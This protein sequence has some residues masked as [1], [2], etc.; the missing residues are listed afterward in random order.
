MI[1]PLVSTAF[2]MFL[3]AGAQQATPASPAPPRDEPVTQFF[4]N[5]GRDLRAVPSRETAEI[6][7][8]AA[9]TA[10]LAHRGDAAVAE[11]AKRQPSSSLGAFGNFLGD[12]W[13]QWGAAASVWFAGERSHQP[14]VAHLGSDL[15][16]AQALNGVINT[17][18]KWTVRRERPTGSPHSFPS[19]HTSATFATAAVLEH[20][21][22]WRAGAVAYGVAAFV[23]WAR[24]R[25]YQHWMSDVVFGAAVGVVSG[26]S[27]SRT[28]P[29]QWT[30]AP[31][32]TVGGIA[33]F[34]TRQPGARR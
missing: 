22:G 6:F 26:R 28:H 18:I 19:G 11:W 7:T 9:A 1:S 15:I 14:R 5:L 30:V 25:T 2:A 32:K 4:Q 24:V 10:L 3:I 21:L 17:A 33:V 29:R 31:V 20:H 23:G 8:G 12:G 27:V 34:V 13:V 16:R